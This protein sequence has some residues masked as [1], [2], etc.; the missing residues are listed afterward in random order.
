[1]TGYIYFSEPLCNEMLYC[2]KDGAFKADLSE[3][4]LKVRSQI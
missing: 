1:M 4:L 2:C 3:T